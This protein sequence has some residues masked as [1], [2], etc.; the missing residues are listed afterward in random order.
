MPQCG[1]GRNGASEGPRALGRLPSA[2]CEGVSCFKKEC[3]TFRLLCCLSAALAAHAA[4]PLFRTSFDKRDWTA[5]EGAATLDPAAP[6]GGGKSLR[7][8]AGASGRGPVVRL[9]PIALTIGKRYELSGW[10]RTEGLTVEDLDRSPIAVGAALTMASMPWDVHSVSVGGA[11]A[12][13]RLSL[14]FVASRAQDAI[15]LTAGCGG[16]IRGKA[17]F[18]GVSLDEATSTDAWPAREAVRTFGPA[19]RYPSG[20]WIYLHIEGAP[21]ERGYQHGR[22]MAPEV[23]EY[24][25]RCAAPSVPRT[26]GTSTAPPPT[27]SFSEASIAKSWRRCAVSPMALRMPE[28]GG[29]GAAS[30]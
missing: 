19:Y 26:S 2:S 14:K 10:V 6:H 13:T 16:S 15:I 27:P 5:I 20:G 8:E 22:L 21:Y 7:L 29:A 9:A 18:E 1:F 23:P 30:T 3:P 17:W 12:W 11:Q 4:T 28:P 25:E 24:L